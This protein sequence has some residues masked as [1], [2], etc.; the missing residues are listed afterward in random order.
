MQVDAK[1]VFGVLFRNPKDAPPDEDGPPVRR[2]EV[3]CWA[4]ARRKFWE[5]AAA[6]NIVAREALVRIAR[7][8]E[9][10][11]SWKDRPPIDIQR[12]K[13]ALLRPHVSAFFAWATA[14]YEKAQDQ[15]GSVRSA[16]GY[17]VRQREALSRFIDD[18]RLRMDKNP[19]ELQLHGRVAVGRKARLFVGSDDHAESAAGIMSLIASA[20]LHRIDPEACLRDIICVLPHWPRDRYIELAPKYWAQ[21]R[22]LLNPA[23]LA[24]EPGDLTVPD[25]AASSSTEQAAPD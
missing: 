23:E 20:R 16:L 19:A 15:R 12:L 4:H 25:P 22:A 14:E 3:G 13:G 8:F 9:L 7:I 18:G 2:L 24:V 5:A 10:D 11:A 17:S 6:K 1:S 21:T